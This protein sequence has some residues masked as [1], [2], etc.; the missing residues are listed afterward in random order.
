MFN[1]SQHGKP[2]KSTSYPQGA[3][4]S[5]TSNHRK[6]AEVSKTSN[7]R[8][9]ANF[10]AMHLDGLGIKFSV[11]S[12]I[13]NYRQEEKPVKPP[14]SNELGYQMKDEL[15]P[16]EDLQELCPEDPFLPIDLQYLED[17]RQAEENVPMPDHRQGTELSKTS[18]QR[19]N[20]EP[21]TSGTAEEG[22]E[23]AVGGQ[24][25][26]WRE[27]M[28]KKLGI[29]SRRERLNEL[30]ASNEAEGYSPK[31]IDSDDE[32]DP[33]LHGVR[34]G[35]PNSTKT[36]TYINGKR[37][38]NLRRISKDDDDDFYFIS[39]DEVKEARRMER[40]RLVNDQ[41]L[42]MMSG[43]LNDNQVIELADYMKESHFFEE[44]E[45]QESESKKQKQTAEDD[46]VNQ[47]LNDDQKDLLMDA[48]LDEVDNIPLETG[49]NPGK[50]LPQS[51]LFYYAM[52]NQRVAALHDHTYAQDPSHRSRQRSN[53]VLK[54]SLKSVGKLPMD[55]DG[56]QSMED[57][58][59]IVVVD[60]HSIS[61]SLPTI[62]HSPCTLTTSNHPTTLS[63]P[64]ISPKTSTAPTSQAT[65]QATPATPNSLFRTPTIH[66]QKNPQQPVITTQHNSST[67]HSQP[68]TT[69]STIACRYQSRM[70][71][72]HH[73][74]RQT[75]SSNHQDSKR[76]VT[77]R[78][79]KF[80]V[81]PVEAPTQSQM[82]LVESI[83][84]VLGP[85]P[86]WSLRNRCKWSRPELDSL[87]SH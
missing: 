80:V 61:N 31:L 27:D 48:L 66:L 50:K 20:S 1:P 81:A 15:I 78:L 72:R 23:G 14:F 85:Y 11:P 55:S 26:M 34:D 10:S 53:N 8:E 84:R 69:Q 44:T 25:S 35:D 83:Q 76:L 36:C 45:E 33:V 37:Y 2:S 24:P 77:M 59:S 79:P 62:V 63:V 13:S 17:L 42:D 87:F 29:T 52:T 49:E 47:E 3:E 16:I 18:N 58:G 75:A 30:L 12:L 86:G 56:Q 68:T 65:S 32:V 22:L 7:H 5:K 54:V 46:V 39:D 57:G 9:D 28:L 6:G 19:Q 21:K 40:K 73:P 43:K 82:A 64:N 41:V 60:D 74:Y 38:W 71:L 67:P 51:M 4:V 70:S